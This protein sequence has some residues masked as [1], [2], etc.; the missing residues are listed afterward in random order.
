MLSELSSPPSAENT[1]NFS[2]PVRKGRRPPGK[3]LKRFANK[4]GIFGLA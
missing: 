1:P 3:I 2:L 4:S